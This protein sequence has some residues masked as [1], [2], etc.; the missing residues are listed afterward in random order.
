[1]ISAG[2]K[3]HGASGTPE[4]RVWCMIKTRCYNKNRRDY[5]WYGADGIIVCDRWL[6]GEGGK[7]GFECFLE[8]MGPRPS[9]KHTIE[10][11][12]SKKN[13]EPENCEWILA[14]LQ[15]QNT[16]QVVKMMYEGEELCLSEVSRRSGIKIGTLG[17]RIRNGWSHE[18]AIK[19]PV[20]SL[21][22]HAPISFNGK[23]QTITQWA[24]EFSVT[25][26]RVYKI[27]TGDFDVELEM[28]KLF[29]RRRNA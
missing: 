2:K 16:R 6:N 7:S 9:P 23:T 18:D 25:Y 13:Y 10:R 11:K 27:V 5:R 20:I 28:Q 15:P 1:M 8:D 12:N 24:D 14:V 21:K 3:T 29:T 17:Q 4:Y 19:T 26:Q 22:E